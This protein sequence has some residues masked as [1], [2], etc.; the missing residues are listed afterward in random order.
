MSVTTIKV[1]THLRDRIA[2]RARE[3]GVPLAGI[4][5]HALD[6]LDE[7]QFWE[8]VRDENAS[9]TREERALYLRS[10]GIDGVA[11]AADDAISERDEW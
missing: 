9:L 5:E 6:M 11:D 3:Q 4:I 7:W 10:G 1:S 2:A 8:S